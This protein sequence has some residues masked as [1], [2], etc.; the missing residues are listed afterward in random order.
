L[1][2][3]LGDSRM[4]EVMLSLGVLRWSRREPLLGLQLCEK[5]LAL[6]EQA[7]DADVLAAAHAGIGLQLFM[8]GQFEKARERLEG[9]PLAEGILVGDTVRCPWHHAC[10]SLRTGE[11]FRAPA[12]DPVIC[13]K[14]ETRGG[15]LFVREKQHEK[16]RATGSAK[17]PE[18]VIIVGG[19]ARQAT[20]R[21]KCCG[22]KDIPAASR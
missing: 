18:K 4:M 19:G 16:K 20:L 11:A 7:K 8:L 6:A 17:A 13:W 3:Q 9:A 10:F 12:L 21:R 2:E 1:C 22:V 15:K 5:A 14:V